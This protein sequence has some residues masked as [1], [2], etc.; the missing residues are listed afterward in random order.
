MPRLKT[1]EGKQAQSA[2]QRKHYQKNKDY[3]KDKASDRKKALRDW[4]TEYKTSLKCNRCP[5]ADA[6]CLDFHHSDPSEKEGN[7][8]WIISRGWSLDK[9]KKEIS[10]CEVLCSNCHRK[11]HAKLRR[12]L[13]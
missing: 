5:E 3:Y 13:A 2:Y 8:G 10:K 9:L 6:D 1:P 12:E 11:H 7:L 4:L